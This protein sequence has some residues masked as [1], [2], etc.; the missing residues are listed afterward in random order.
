MSLC[1]KPGIAVSR[2]KRDSLIAR[3]FNQGSGKLRRRSVSR[4]C[5]GFGDPPCPLQRFGIRMGAG[6]LARHRLNLRRERQVR[7]N[8]SIQAMSKRILRRAR[9][10]CGVFS[11]VLDLALA[12]FARRRR[13]V[14]KVSPPRQPRQSRRLGTP[15]PR[16]LRLID[17]RPRQARR[18]D[19]RSRGARCS[20]APRH[21]PTSGRAVQ[22][23]RACFPGS[24]PPPHRSSGPP[25]REWRRPS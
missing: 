17:A 25:S 9:L 6:D 16:S 4:Q 23:S 24:A 22:S 11:P 15:R 1:P 8:R 14:F 5:S 3:D 13:S 10:S 12:R 2:L 7:E 20:D 18:G 21:S 19:D